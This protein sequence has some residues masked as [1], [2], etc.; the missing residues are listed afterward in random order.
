M[1]TVYFTSY[2]YNIHTSKLPIMKINLLII[3]V[4]KN[5]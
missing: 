4:S 3:N 5:G 2:M 1:N